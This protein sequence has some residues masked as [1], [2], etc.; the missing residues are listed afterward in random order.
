MYFL[1]LL[2]LLLSTSLLAQPKGWRELT[3][4]DGLSQGMIYD[5]KQDSKGFIWVATKDG[6]NRYDG[7]N[8]AIFTHDPYNKYSISD[9]AC[10]ALLI[11]RRGRLWVGTL[12]QGLNLYD[13]QTQRFYHIDINDRRS[14]NA[15]NY[16]I[17][18][19]SE[20][21]EG[22]IWVNTNQNKLFKI[23]LPDELKTGYPRVVNFTSQ[24]T[25]GQIPL[26]GMSGNPSVH[27]IQFRA[28]GSAIVG[29]TAGMCAFNWRRMADMRAFN[30][31]LDVLPRD[32]VVSDDAGAGDY[33]FSATNDH[34]HAWRGT[35]HKTIRLPRET[36]SVMVKLVDSNTV[37]VATLEYLWL[38]S[39]AQ[40]LTQESL[41]SANAFTVMPSGLYGLRTL[42]KDETGLVWIG[43]T[44]YGLRVFNPTVK[45]FRTY[46]PRT[47]LTYLFEDR[48]GRS[49]VRFMEQ[50]GQLDR[51]NNRLVPFLQTKLQR[52]HQ[53]FLTQ[54]R[55]GFFWT[56]NTD[57][58]LGVHYLRKYSADWQLLKTYP[59]PTQAGLGIY[60]NQIIEDQT[61]QLWIGATKGKLLRFNPATE[62][63][64]M[65]SYAHLLP[66]SGA[67]IETYALYFDGLGTLWIG[68]PRG[69]FRADHP[70]TKP[71]FSRYKNS[72]S[73]RQS[74][75][76]DVVSNMVDDPYEPLHYLWVST[77][78]GGLERLDKQT[79]HFRHFT[80]AQ[81]LPN[82][83][84]YG[85]LVDSFKNLWMST[86]RGLAQLNPRT[87][88]FRT[89]TKADGLQDD[90]FNT[91]SFFKAASGKLLFG[92]VN[93]LTEFD[94]REIVGRVIPEV[95]IVGLR[96]NNEP[97]TAGAPDGIL[98]KSL[99]SAPAVNLS[100]D[101]NGV[102]LEFAVMDFTNPAK[103]RYRYQMRG[104]D[105]DWVEG[106]TNRF[107]NYAQLPDGNYTFQLIGSSDGQHWSKPVELQ[108]RV[109]PPFYRTWWAYLL[110]TIF[111]A[112][113]VWQF[114]RVQTQRLLLEQQIVYEQKEATRLAELD[115][116]K[117]QFF[118]NI[119][120]EFRTPL[121]LILGPLADLRQRFPAEAALGLMERNGQ[122]LLNLINQL[123]DLGKLE[124]GQLRI[125][126][127][128]GDLAT[129][130]RT[131]AY[132]FQS[133]AESRQIT[134]SFQQPETEWWAGF[135]RDK[136]EKIV[137][138]LLSNAIKFTPSGG[139][140]G[141]TVDYPLDANEENVRFTVRDTGIGIAQDQLAHI[142]ERFYQV[143]G[144]I[145]RLYEG[146]G[147]GLAL[148]NE[149]VK[150]MNGTITVTSVEGQGTTFIVSLPITTVQAGQTIRSSSPEEAM[151]VQWGQ[152]KTQPDKT[153]VPP[154]PA[155][156]EDNP[157]LLIIDDNADIRV[158]VRSI[159]EADYQIIEATDGQEG[160]AVAT[161]T[162]PDVVVCDLM[163]PRLD[164]FGFCQALKTQE[165]TSH[166][167]V[168]MLTAKA[169]VEDRIE[170]F[171]RGADDYLT[172]PFNRTELQTRVR[173]LIE[174][175]K[176]L[177]GW[178][179][180]QRS[181]T[182]IVVA[183]GV[184]TNTTVTDTT[185]KSVPALTLLATEQAFIDRLT[186]IVHQ[187]LSEPDFSVEALAD[188]INLSRSQLHRKVKA[189]LDTSPTGF[190]RDIRLAKAAELLTE[191]NQSVT[192]V[193]YAVG[194]D[195]L[196]YFAKTFQERYGVSPSQY[197]RA[198]TSPS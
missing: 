29:T 176:R 182:D 129:F 75:S 166:I 25:F 69:L 133:L 162:L 153:T 178:F 165:A 115:G 57:D 157:V 130:F 36:V 66:Q 31:P 124:A 106:G 161:S 156:G 79:G 96:I 118:T 87:F 16:E 71:S 122:R 173:N 19:L 142:F 42:T 195:N 114:F 47:S 196:S 34:I 163:M 21:P 145:S 8:F 37:A 194:F 185:Q 104:V 89:F 35:T 116:L 184:D 144:Q 159:F 154:L 105:D 172:K 138:N 2:F 73:D 32:W 155:A 102:T 152:L 181:V 41:S 111:L 84:V 119:S 40:L 193:A 127:E 6:L 101:Q 150:V 90:E 70:L 151:P 99:E 190:I 39:P 197:G 26:V 30:R 170:G 164:G 20:D 113:A 108:I 117:T 55:A 67:E 3:I 131:M 22:N 94:P 53:R 175:R 33:W 12:N 132:S 83:V 24:A 189:L 121:T 60:L 72:S 14:A 28:D 63:F 88:A 93:G 45:R 103:N 179:S 50:Y 61:G 167:P 15:G 148:V 169:T 49:Y 126:T 74:L 43:T 78:G 110:Y 120:H 58:N 68:T 125:K 128:S 18:L 7:H 158:Y 109:H 64:T 171:E 191:G 160:L 187:H 65:Y 135:D 76:N 62:A 86:N 1:S 140:V 100:Y 123:L 112:V 186:R 81:G 137:T 5:L 27:H 48:Q 52:E 180:Q 149:L 44:G 17:R 9:D 13:A 177:Y 10:S 147:I 80:E 38:M 23:T 85:I 95:H 91:G 174:Q 136:L 92:G 82:K 168:V 4:S 54:S 188:A 77:K 46:L 107:A 143:D 146:T 59:L 134:F 141:M 11:D 183:D 192:Q 51:A 98:P 139:D 97:V 56:S 198:A